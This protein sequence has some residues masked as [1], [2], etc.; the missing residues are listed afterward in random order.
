M[1]LE[2]ISELV[3]RSKAGDREALETLLIWAHTPVSYLCRTILQDPELAQ[4]Q[5]RSV[6]RALSR[7]LYNL[8][9]PELFEKWACKIT[10]ESCMQVF[11]QMEDGATAN[12][13]LR[14]SGKNLDRRG[15]VDVIQQLVDR[16]PGELR[17]TLVLYCCAGMKSQVIADVMGVEKEDA[18]ENLS[19]SQTILQ[20]QIDR[21]MERGIQFSEI[22]SLV[23]ILRSAMYQN[24]DEQSAS[25]M[26][27][28]ILGIGADAEEQ[29]LENRTVK[30]LLWVLIVLVSLIIVLLAGLI[31]KAK[32]TPPPEVTLPTWVDTSVT[33]PAETEA[34]AEETV[35]EVVEETTEETTAQ[36]TAPT[37]EE[38]KTAEP[39][40]AEV[41]KES[42]DSTAES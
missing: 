24:E 13:P 26:V 14:L 2:S 18:R 22:S 35:A 40:E 11:Y 38:T 6:L 1:N 39:V 41:A 34:P 27:W 4:E 16:L 25:D 5:T 28:D 36:T 33:E 12:A 17:T 3:M 20:K 42:A 8:E 29:P 31:V 9:D 7:Q 23:D 19:R 32:L 30:A 10:A 15:T 21:C 37:E